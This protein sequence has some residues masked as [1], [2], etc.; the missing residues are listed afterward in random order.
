M[1]GRCRRI[2]GLGK[3]GVEEEAPLQSSSTFWY[4]PS[5]ASPRS[6]WF[7]FSACCAKW[8][9]EVPVKMLTLLAAMLGPICWTI[10]VAE[11]SGHIGRRWRRD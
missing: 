3:R 5:N 4:D 7:L 1:R 2:Q 6:P 8:D 10:D 9:V 11:F